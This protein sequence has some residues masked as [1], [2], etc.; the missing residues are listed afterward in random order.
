MTKTTTTRNTGNVLEDLQP[1]TFGQIGWRLL[2][3]SYWKAW[4]AA[5]R[6]AHKMHRRTDPQDGVADNGDAQRTAFLDQLD[7]ND[8]NGL[9]TQDAPLE[10]LSQWK[11]V[12]NS[13][14]PLVKVSQ[15]PNP[16]EFL[17]EAMTYKKPELSAA[18]IELRMKITG[19]TEE[20]II[21][22]TNRIARETWDE[23]LAIMENAAELWV[24]YPA[25]QKE[26]AEFR[27][28]V[29]EKMDAVRKQAVNDKFI[30]RGTNTMTLLGA[31]M[32]L[33]GETVH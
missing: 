3:T 20:E 8:N 33:L 1:E 18:D 17:E 25:G 15:R 29:I 14:M 23:D 6:E 22:H 5:M 32:E 31:E 26:P 4:G 27:E 30:E 13:V 21:E 9:E 2:M 10:Q 16:R 28:V 24:T 12:I 11:Y 19:Q 7:F